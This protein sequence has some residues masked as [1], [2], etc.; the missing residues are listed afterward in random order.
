MK[1]DVMNL[2]LVETTGVFEMTQIE[3]QKKIW[4]KQS[5]F[6]ILT[7]TKIVYCKCYQIS[8]LKPNE[9]TILS[10]YNLIKYRRNE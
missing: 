9:K 10:K 5:S 1:L 3:K 6:R 7:T 2:T 4:R 8:G